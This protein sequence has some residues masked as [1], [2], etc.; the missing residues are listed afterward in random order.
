VGLLLQRASF[1]NAGKGE[2]E[3]GGFLT[4]AGG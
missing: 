1:G 4:N 2:A 3:A